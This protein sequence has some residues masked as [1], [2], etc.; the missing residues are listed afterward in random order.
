MRYMPDSAIA[1]TIGNARRRNA[2]ARKRNARRNARIV[3]QHWTGKD[4]I[5][6]IALMI[7]FIIVAGLFL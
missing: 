5:G 1:G 2:I 4:V 3:Q 7:G 6:G